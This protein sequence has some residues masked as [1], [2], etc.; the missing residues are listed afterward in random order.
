MQQPQRPAR[1]RRNTVD[2]FVASGLVIFAVVVLLF[3]SKCSMIGRT[4]SAI[5]AWQSR[6]FAPKPAITINLITPSS[7]RG[8]IRIYTTADGAVIWDGKSQAVTIDIPESGWVAISGP[9]PFTMW[10]RLSIVS[11][12]GDS[13][14][15]RG[16][17][18]VVGPDEYAAEELGRHGTGMPIVVFLGTQSESYKYI[19]E[20]ILSPGSEP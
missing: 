8:A 4:A 3:V 13:I 7:F 11:S 1:A 14:P 16:G 19:K 10:H 5:M 12:Q 20:N 15:V 18:S 9:D 17:Q 6:L 2:A